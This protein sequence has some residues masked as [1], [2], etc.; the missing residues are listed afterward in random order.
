MHLD[1]SSRPFIFPFS[2]SML[3]SQP[4]FT[5]KSVVLLIIAG[6]GLI[7]GLTH[8]L[9]KDIATRVQI[10]GWICL[11]TALSVFVAP[12]GILRTVIKTKSVEFMPFCLSFF[13]TISAVT[14][15]LYGLFLKDFNIWVPNVVGFAFGILQMVLYVIYKDTKKQK[16]PADLIP[17]EIIILDNQ[18]KLPQQIID[19]V[20]L[21]ALAPSEKN[22]FLRTQTSEKNIVL[23]PQTSEK[24]IVLRTQSEKNIVLCPQVTA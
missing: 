7:V 22:I 11:V 1:V 21:G 17:G 4:G 14:W 2:C 10:V 15:F 18:E 16:L 5:M 13:L 8:F 24:N 23:R 12:L 6:F 19:I 9:V 20:K 3:T